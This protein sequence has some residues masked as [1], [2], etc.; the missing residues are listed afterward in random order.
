M[1]KPG[2]QAVFANGRHGANG[3]FDIEISVSGHRRVRRISP[4]SS[5]G[6]HEA[7]RVGALQVDVVDQR[8]KVLLS[9]RGD[10]PDH[11]GRFLKR[12]LLRLHLYVHVFNSIKD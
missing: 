6:A 5:E 2:G 11:A 4:G 3:A 8:G 9:K 10:L 7:F 1:Q 12:R